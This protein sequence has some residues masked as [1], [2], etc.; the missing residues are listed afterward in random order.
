MIWKAI[1]PYLL[2]IQINWILMRSMWESETSTR[3]SGKAQNEPYICRETVGY[4][5]FFFFSSFSSPPFAGPF[6]A[7]DCSAVPSWAIWINYAENHL[8]VHFVW[9]Y[10]FAGKVNFEGSLNGWK[11]CSWG[12]GVLRRLQLLNAIAFP[13][14]SLQREESVE[15]L[16]L[17]WHPCWIIVGTGAN[18][19]KM[20]P[21]FKSCQLVKIRAS[22][23]QHH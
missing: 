2:K 3:D 12:A 18:Q 9:N 1:K 23:I 17:A 15:M 20:S 4:I 13:P 10:I 11:W 8:V 7:R 16:N 6:G 22:R 19:Q 14:R 5:N 21:Q